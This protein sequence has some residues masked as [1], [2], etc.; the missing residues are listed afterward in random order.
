MMQIQR[1]GRIEQE[2]GQGMALRHARRAPKKKEARREEPA[3]SW[4]LACSAAQHQRL[5][6]YMVISNP[7]RS[8]V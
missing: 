6:M 1:V 3:G 8:S 4:S 5:A 2:V 7:S